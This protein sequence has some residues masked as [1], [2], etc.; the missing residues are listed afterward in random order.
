MR[1]LSELLGSPA[2]RP[3]SLGEL[4]VMSWAAERL[5][6]V[7]AARLLGGRALAVDFDA[8]L[9]DVGAT[10][11]RVL[12]HFA[13][14][15]PGIAHGEILGRYS[16]APEHAYSPSLRR[17]LLA[18]ARRN[19]GPEIRDALA[20]LEKLRIANPSHAAVL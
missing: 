17:E 10:L 12:A 8:M 20:W 5:T 3:R 6:Q 13:I 14:A 4:I 2:P 9:D 1:R 18:Q 15:D 16:K 7:H 11:A 19:F